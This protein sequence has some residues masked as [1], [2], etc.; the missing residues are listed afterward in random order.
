V[1][2]SPQRMDRHSFPGVSRSRQRPVRY[3][4][5]SELQSRSHRPSTC[6]KTWS[7]GRTRKNLDT[8][9]DRNW[10]QRAMTDWPHGLELR[11][12][13]WS[14][15]HLRFDGHPDSVEL[16]AGTA[17]V[18]EQTPAASGV[19]GQSNRGNPEAQVAEPLYREV[20]EE[21]ERRRS[22]RVCRT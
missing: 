15:T 4:T 13:I 12:R 3:H 7:E 17:V 14:E 22:K 2:H 18:E 8:G 9:S 6:H 10:L 20:G 1:I 11:T 19:A 21:R 5:A 16:T